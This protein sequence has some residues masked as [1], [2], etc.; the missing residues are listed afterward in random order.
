MRD[1]NQTIDDRHEAKRNANCFDASTIFDS[2]SAM[3]SNDSQNSKEK[4]T[5]REAKPQHFE[6]ISK[7]IGR[8]VDNSTSAAFQAEIGCKLNVK[9]NRRKRNIQTETMKLLTAN[10]Q[11]KMPEPRSSDIDSRLSSDLN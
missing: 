2:T 8:I 5:P 10:Y 11:A 3:A 6:V 1:T 7:S 9:R 4:Q